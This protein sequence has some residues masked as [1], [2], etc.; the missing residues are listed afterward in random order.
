MKAQ[1]IIDFQRH[2]LEHDPENLENRRA[3]HETFEWLE[4]YWRSHNHLV[5]FDGFCREYGNYFGGIAEI[6]T[7][8]QQLAAEGVVGNSRD[9]NY[10]PLQDVRDATNRLNQGL[11]TPSER[12]KDTMQIVRQIRNNLFH[13]RKMEWTIVDQYERNKRLVR[14]AG[15]ITHL[16]LANLTVGEVRLGL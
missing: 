5:N 3:F 11:G 10:Q 4:G 2:L 16:L 1:E 15:A 7:L 8:A 9:P 12:F 6:E 13:G 14:L